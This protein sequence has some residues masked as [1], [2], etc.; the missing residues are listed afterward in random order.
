MKTPKA[1][2]RVR[3]LP[4]SWKALGRSL[5]KRNRASFIQQA[6][7]DRGIKKN[8]LTCLGKEDEDLHYSL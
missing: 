6:L 5:S 1:V 2:S 7:R 8:I 4:Q 3:C